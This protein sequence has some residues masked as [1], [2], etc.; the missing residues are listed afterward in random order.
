MKKNILTIH[1]GTNLSGAGKSWILLIE[2]LKDKYNVY[3]S[4]PDRF[5]DKAID[6][7]REFIVPCPQINRKIINNTYYFLTFLYFVYRY[8][9]IILKHKID[10][11][12]CN[13]IYLLQP[14]LAAK[15]CNKKLVV[16]VREAREKY[17]L[18]LHKIWVLYSSLLADTIICASKKDSEN[19]SRKNL[20]YVPNWISAESFL[21]EINM[22]SNINDIFIK[23]NHVNNTKILVVSQLIQGKGHDF[24]IDIFNQLKKS[25]DNVCLYIAGGTNN[26]I[27]NIRYEKYII[28]KINNLNLSNDV[29]LLGEVRNI[30]SV[31]KE[32]DYVIMPSR[33]ESFS[34]VY[35]EAMFCKKVLIATNVGATSEL[36]SDMI[37]GVIINYGEVDEACKKI[38]SVI[39]NKDLINTIKENAYNKVIEDYTDTKAGKL[40]LEVLDN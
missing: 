30:L 34:R 20:F 31:M 14:M 29:I 24:A 28:D 33:S 35:L 26:N 23:N 3:T 32:F 19:F 12:Y 9:S 22:P 21:S 6:K 27:N 16:H 1:P 13:G 17:P 39:N 11:V 7:D 38:I 37:D 4:T 2:T 15:L 40:F 18:I 25:T 10:M 5:T 36:F 8:I